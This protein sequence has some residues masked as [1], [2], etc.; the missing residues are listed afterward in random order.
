MNHSYNE[1]DSNFSNDEYV[2]LIDPKTGNS[3]EGRIIAIKGEEILVE[4]LKTR[5]EKMYKKNDKRIIKQWS[6][7]KPIKRYNRVDFQLKGTD[8]WVVGVV[9]RI[10]PNNKI[11]IRYQNNNNFKPIGEE[12]IDINDQRIAKVGLY[13]KFDLDKN[14]LLSSTVLNLGNSFFNISEI[15]SSNLNLLNNKR[16][17]S[18]ENNKALNSEDEEDNFQIL[19]LQSNL[20]IR[21][22]K[23]DGNCLFRAV[24]DQVYG[25]DQYYELIREKCMDYLVIMRKFFEPYI[26]E[27]FDDYI[28]EKRKDKTWGDDIE[29]EALSEIYNRPIEIYKGSNKPLK[30]FHENK[31]FSQYD[32]NTNINFSLHPI[33]LSYHNKNHYNSIIPLETDDVNYRKY[34][35]SLIKSKPGYF[36]SKMIKNAEDNEAELEKGIQ[37][38]NDFFLRLKNNLSEKIEDIANKNYLSEEDEEEQDENI[39]S[40]KIKKEESKEKNEGKIYKI[41]KIDKEKEIKNKNIENND[42]DNDNFLSNSTIKSAVELG[43]DIEDAIDAWCN[44]GDNKEL[45]INYLLNKNNNIN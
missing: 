5:K 10:M 13:T 30:S 34:K 24:S 7:G 32:T 8:Y 35:D 31:Y 36:E 11:L 42:T 25:T 2:D 33:R 39:K 18:N 12:I 26:G 3:Y 1:D 16:K 9:A 6:P 37:V 14:K 20:R 44:Y 19:L 43:Y 29:I 41:N 40:K 22:V 27:D 15:K 4:N 23:G 17:R 38:S 28:K 45:V 21:E